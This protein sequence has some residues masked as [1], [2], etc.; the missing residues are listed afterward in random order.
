MATNEFSKLISQQKE[1]KKITQQVQELNKLK[2]ESSRITEHLEGIMDILKPYQET[3]VPEVVESANIFHNLVMRQYVRMVEINN[4]IEQINN[5]INN[6]INILTPPSEIIPYNPSSQFLLQPLNRPTPGA[7]AEEEEEENEEEEFYSEILTNNP[8]DENEETI[9]EKLRTIN[10]LEGADTMGDIFTEN[11]E[12]RANEIKNAPSEPE[13][14]FILRKKQELKY[15]TGKALADLQSK[16]QQLKDK[17]GTAL[18]GLQSKTQQDIERL[19]KSIQNKVDTIRTKVDTPKNDELEK[20]DSFFNNLMI[21]IVNLSEKVEKFIIRYN[22]FKVKYD[23][24]INTNYVNTGEIKQNNNQENNLPINN[25]NF[26]PF[27]FSQ[28]INTN[29][30]KKRPNTR[31]KRPSQIR[32]KK[33]SSLR[34]AASINQRTKKLKNNYNKIHSKKRGEMLKKRI[35]EPP[36]PPPATIQD[37]GQ[38][39]MKDQLYRLQR[40]SEVA[41]KAI[42][43][44]FSNF[45]KSASKVSQRL[46]NKAKK[47]IQPMAAEMK[48]QMQPIISDLLELPP[49]QAGINYE[50]YYRDNKAAA[51]EVKKNVQPP[52]T[53]PIA[54]PHTQRVRS[55]GEPGSSLKNQLR[56][57]DNKKF[58][59]NW[60]KFSNNKTEWN[61][62]LP[63]QKPP[64]QSKRR[65]AKRKSNS[66]KK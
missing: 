16:T 66:K 52:L 7:A 5:H 12:K 21:E 53:V 4:E 19:G 17:T 35:N 54:P 23:I 65:T 29:R 41:P 32:P 24:N 44:S 20:P 59:N 6:H 30:T 60:K 18:K 8:E 64:N 62:A 49:G 2:E 28:I 10:A 25:K 57:K 45:Y 1:I 50:P 14:P 51:E 11:P 22:K 48:R 37:M 43:K 15:K 40:L 61:K 34:S 27:H 56:N 63:P 33:I 46:T 38:K 3:N 42:P 39:H 9:E 31:K 55:V 26:S 58:Q 47:Q 13:L 36:P